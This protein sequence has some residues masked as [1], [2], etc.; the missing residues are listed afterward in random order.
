[1]AELDNFLNDIKP[2]NPQSQ[3]VNDFLSD[4]S[5]SKD[6]SLDGFLKDISG[7]NV[8]RETKKDENGKV[9]ET[10]L[11][12]EAQ[13]Q[14]GKVL[15]KGLDIWRMSAKSMETEG[16]K[17]VLKSVDQVQKAQGYLEGIQQKIKGLD[18][19]KVLMTPMGKYYARVGM[20]IP[21]P[22]QVIDEVAPQAFE[23]PQ[24]W[25]TTYPPWVTAFIKSVNGKPNAA[26]AKFSQ[27]V[28]LDS[29]AFG[30]FDKVLA[31]VMPR[32]LSGESTLV[33]VEKMSPEALALYNR[34][35]AIS[36]QAKEAKV[37]KEAQLNV[38]N[39]QVK[40]LEDV[41]SQLQVFADE[42]SSAVVNGVKYDVSDNMAQPIRKATLSD[43]LAQRK[44]T[45]IENEMPETVIP[46]DLQVEDILPEPGH[47]G[48]IA[49]TTR[50]IKKVLSWVMSPWNYA[51][52]V[53]DQVALHKRMI[54]N[55][56]REGFGYVQDYFGKF[57]KEQLEALGAVKDKFEGYGEV[58]QNWD[59]IFGDKAEDGMR[60]L[61]AYRTGWNK[62]ADVLELPANMRQQDYLP[63]IIDFY[64]NHVELIPDEL[65]IFLTNNKKFLKERIGAKDYS[66]DIENAYKVYNKWASQ[67]LA[68]KKYQPTIMEEV[69]N[70]Y[71]LNPEYG[72]MAH[73]YALNY[74]GE[75]KKLDKV[76]A[77]Q[78]K[79]TGVVGK[80][81]SD[82]LI[83][84]NIATPLANLTQGPYFGITELGA[85]KWSRGLE[86]ALEASFGKGPRAEMLQK[87]WLE[88]G[89]EEMSNVEYYK[90]AG[91]ITDK[92]IEKT[93][94]SKAMRDIDEIS[95]KGMQITELMNKKPMYLGAYAEAE[96]IAKKVIKNPGKYKRLEQWLQYNGI[97][98]SKNLDTEFYKYAHFKTVKTMQEYS[99]AGQN[100]LNM[101][102][103]VAAVMRIVNFPLRAGEYVA[104][105]TLKSGEYIAKAMTKGDPMLMRTALTMPETVATLRFGLGTF[106][107]KAIA[108]KMGLDISKI[109]GVQNFI[110][111]SS[112]LFGICDQI[113]KA[114]TAWDERDPQWTNKALRSVA[115]VAGFKLTAPAFQVARFFEA[116]K[117]NQYNYSGKWKVYAGDFRDPHSD[118][119]GE[120]DPIWFAFSILSPIKFNDMQG[121]RDWIKE[122][123][124]KQ[125]ELNNLR[126][127]MEIADAEDDLN[128]SMRLQENFDALKEVQQN[129]KEKFLEKHPKVE[130]R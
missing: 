7:G 115:T 22:S 23:L 85:T 8:P 98:I 69:K 118:I 128:K 71:K 97:D 46:K 10:I 21:T 51:R 5:G 68:T 35:L 107:L 78:M 34:E 47:P 121:Y 102:P 63:H 77:A 28:F 29:L 89:L 95:Y 101:T 125:R 58:L 39:A 4:I 86:H 41:N 6:D 83:A 19:M 84:N 108:D 91:S 13:T 16:E 74:F 57:N 105:N 42:N 67:F 93:L 20:N 12:P 88:S 122:N 80:T 55:L 113:A 110:V 94:G 117:A 38:K 66:L 129:E 32:V 15:A 120:V 36:E 3:E 81:I 116:A 72:D 27:M 62:W 33:E 130:L 56:Q 59:K 9:K 76:Y 24:D 53:Y 109:V 40:E 114:Y 99:K 92:L 31:K 61:E 30:G 90:E 52:P 18:F 65:R 48:F 70:I 106:A 25:E 2:S 14:V 54:Q 96:E 87:R 103:G 64:N 75:Y 73:K 104:Y 119:V 126:K 26:V 37:L 11:S 49:N 43:E 1:M 44:L 17:L 79:A 100:S 124:R 112:P 45:S 111:S 60:A 82:A 123:A 50:G 127:Q